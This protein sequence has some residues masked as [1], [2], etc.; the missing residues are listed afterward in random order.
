MKSG[1]A[2][3]V[4]KLAAVTKGIG[5][6]VARDVLVGIPQTKAPREGDPM[7]NATIGY[8]M[9]NGSPAANIPA[10][11]WL[12]PGVK[13]VQAEVAAELGGA[14][15]AALSGQPG[16]IAGNL[17]R[18]G[19]TAQNAVRAKI[20]SGDF[21]PLSDATLRARARRGKR[22]SKGARAEL[23]SRA[24]GNAPSTASAKPLIDSGQFRNSVGYVV[25]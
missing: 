12:V 10:R 15:K 3:T 20:N 17:E 2:M 11:P 5:A 25:R 13:D 7:N 9:E 8:I 14:A 4:D 6:L 21:T 24:A 16:A 23:A 18:A 22:G 19:L 1:A